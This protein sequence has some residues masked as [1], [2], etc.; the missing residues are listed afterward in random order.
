M[1]S[2]SPKTPIS[3]TLVT[4]IHK[5]VRIHFKIDF[6]H[7]SNNLKKTMIHHDTK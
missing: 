5:W 3:E 2:K 4:K 1:H 6:D 7:G